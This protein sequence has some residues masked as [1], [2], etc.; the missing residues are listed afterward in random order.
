[1]E[2]QICMYCSET[3]SHC[4]S[5]EPNNSF[6]CRF[7]RDMHELS[8]GNHLVKP[9]ASSFFIPVPES[10]KALIEKITEIRDQAIRK[11]EF[12]MNHLNKELLDINAEIKSIEEN[13]EGFIDICDKILADINS[14]EKISSKQIQSPLENALISQNINELISTFRAPTIDTPRPREK[15]FRFS[16]STFPQSLF[17][18]HH[19]AVENISNQKIKIF[20]SEKIIKCSEFDNCSRSLILCNKKILITGG[21]GYLA[22]KC[23]ILDTET[24]IIKELPSLNSG[25]MN[26]AITW[27]DNCPAVISGAFNF[28][29]IQNVE[30]FKHE[31]WT[32]IAPVNIPRS[33]H[34]VINNCNVV[35]MIG[36][37]NRGEQIT[38]NTIEKFENN[39]WK[40][41]KIKLAMPCQAP[42]ISCLNKNILIAGGYNYEGLKFNSQVYLFDT[43]NEKIELVSELKIE[44]CYPQNHTYIDSK[45]ISVKGFFTKQLASLDLKDL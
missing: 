30:I 28:I 13:F 39:Y 6:F 2:V 38:R 25:R 23:F 7:H 40:L 29:D 42:W 36:G 5:C 8:L 35:W 14:I 18:Y 44:D 4:C 41:L 43:L 9:L 17:Q 45:N 11:F 19:I 3:A 10:K 31:H 12:A 20:P 26:H 24:E 27:I 34:S 32:Q 1:M 33:G 16:S 21:K 22:N 15:T 37:I